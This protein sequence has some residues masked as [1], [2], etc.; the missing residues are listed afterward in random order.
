MPMI[1]R[2]VGGA[3]T[4]KTT[5]LLE[6]MAMSLESGIRDPLQIGFV[7]FTRAARR[8][9]ST[10]AG[11]ALGVRPEEL[12]SDGWFRTLHSVCHKCLKV[13]REMIGSTRDDRKWLEGVLDTEATPLGDDNF[14]D[15]VFSQASVADLALSLWDASRNRLIPLQTI[16]EQAAKIDYRI[17][18]FATIQGIVERY[19]QAKRLDGR[20]DFSDILCRFAGKACRVEG[21]YDRQPEGDVPGVPVWF[22]DECQDSS[23]LLHEV[24]K[25][26]MQ[27]SRWCYLVGDPF[28][29]IYGFSGASSEHFMGVEVAKQ[30]VLNKSYRCPS[31]IHQLGERILRQ[32]SDYWD[33][34]IQPAD[35]A[36]SVEYRPYKLGVAD[37]VNPNEEWLVLARSNYHARRIAET[38][39][40]RNI[41]WVP[42]R[43]R[44]GWNAPVRNAGLLTL[45]SLQRGAPVDGSQWQQAV[46]LIPSSI[47]GLGLLTRGTKTL[48]DGDP[49]LLAERYPWIQIKDLED[50]GATPLMEQMIASG[51]WREVVPQAESFLQAIDRWGEDIVANP[52]ID[53]GPPEQRRG[54]RLGTIH[55]AKGCEANNVIYLTSTSDQV[56]KGQEEQAGYNEERRVE[57]VAVTRARQRLLV[58]YDK[59]HRKAELPL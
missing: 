26:L 45:L 33:R 8:E 36:G 51:E 11:D 30:E 47:D 29:S 57:Y 39:D 25:R 5:R 43:G 3:G 23:A 42:T 49:K 15:L 27:H 55:S 56:H 54:V 50:V 13:G 10:R 9:A 34:Q 37:E 7:S 48:F 14:S 58:A 20:S 21:I 2:I 59:S 38:L 35:H 46:K 40:R 18:E 4:G 1:A 32:C 44:G 52:V 28:Q 6:L 16:W 22:F 24:E 17:P 41:P 31:A 12:E 19:E 53:S